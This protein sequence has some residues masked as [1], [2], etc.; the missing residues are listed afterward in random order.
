MRP[1]N[2]L[3]SALFHSLYRS[4]FIST[5]FALL[6]ILLLIFLSIEKDLRQEGQ[7]LGQLVF[8]ELRG[9]M[10]RGASYEEVNHLIAELNS[11]APDITY[12]MYRSQAIEEQFGKG[13]NLTSEIQEKLG[14]SEDA[15]SIESIQNIHYYRAIKFENECL[16]CHKNVAAGDTAG[17]L[18]VIFSAQ[19]IRIPISEVLMGLFLVFSVTMITCYL[20]LSR[21]LLSHMVKPLQRLGRKLKET[22][23]HHDLSERLDLDSNL[24]EIKTIE[25]A[26]NAQQALLHIAFQKVE[27]VSIYDKLTSTYNRHQLDRLFNEETVRSIRQ[28]IPMT[29]AMLDLNGFK[30]I[31]DTY[32]HQA[33]D[34]ILI[35]FCKT[36]SEGLRI[37]DKVV[38]YGG[39]EFIVL[40]P[41]CAKAK[42]EELFTRI[43]AM[44]LSTPYHYKGQAIHIHFSTGFAEYPK[45]SDTEQGLDLIQR[46]DEQMYRDKQRRKSA[47]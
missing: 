14:G 46:A 21:D 42:A 39:D 43:E 7:Y 45:E 37:T 19:R 8:K 16:Q 15:T 5:A 17:V 24:K 29:V 35:H 38:R 2:S 10:N 31:N 36:F 4:S 47:R 40:L 32:G 27:E 11:D 13:R 22:E 34:E 26:F 28:Q 3:K 20:T 44:V 12:A 6:I 9:A 25:H 1:V 23:G 41:D 18:D 33:G 30:Q